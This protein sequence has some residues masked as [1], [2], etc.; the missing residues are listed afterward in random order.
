MLDE[1]GVGIITDILNKCCW[2]NELMVD[3]LELAELVTLYKKVNVEDPANYRPIAL[4][5]TI[6]KLY[7][8]IL[9]TRL[10]AG[11]DG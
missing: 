4:L 7:A 1:E 5:N 11:L 9:Q 3:E 10:A 6:S 8:A 2:A